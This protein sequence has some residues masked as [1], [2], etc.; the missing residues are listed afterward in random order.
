MYKLVAL[1]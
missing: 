1:R